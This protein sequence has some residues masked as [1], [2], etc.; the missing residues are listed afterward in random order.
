VAGE[1]GGGEALQQRPVRRVEMA[2]RDEVVRQGAALVAGPGV[3]GGDQVRLV[4]QAVL[5]REQA[6]EEI[7]RGISGGRHGDRPPSEESRNQDSGEAL[8][9]IEGQRNGAS[10]VR[11]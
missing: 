11:L 1:V 9:P 8:Y 6:D 2:R 3:K 4:D 10:E 7:A 5:E